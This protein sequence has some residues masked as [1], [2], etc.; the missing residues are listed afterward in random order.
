MKFFIDLKP[1]TNVIS[2]YWNTDLILFHSF[3]QISQSKIV[4]T[5][6]YDVI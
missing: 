2:Y 6:Q 1:G 4:Y 5:I 3:L